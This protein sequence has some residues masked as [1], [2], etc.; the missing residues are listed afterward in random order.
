MEIL[1]PETFIPSLKHKHLLID[2]N[3][4]RDAANRPSVFTKFFNDL[5][6]ADITIG[7]TDFVKYELLKG[8]A[9]NSK[10]DNKDKFISEIID[11]TIPIHARTFELVYE[12]IKQYGI[13][14]STAHIT[15]LLLGACLMQY[16]TNIYLMTRDTTDFI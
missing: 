11:V 14:G 12:L 16:K 3:V 9:D 1:Y 10:Y 4:L 6:K 13:D 5:K 7:T 15:D 8:S 2:T